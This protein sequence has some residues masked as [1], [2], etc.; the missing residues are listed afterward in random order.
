MTV[1]VIFP[2]MGKNRAKVGE[3]SHFETI[4]PVEMGEA[5]QKF[6]ILNCCSN[7][8]P[9]TPAVTNAF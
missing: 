2:K 4:L 3:N 6:S 8:N 5:L 9:P 7:P 1:E